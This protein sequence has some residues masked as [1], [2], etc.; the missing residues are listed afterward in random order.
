MSWFCDVF[1]CKWA[2][3]PG[4]FPDYCVRCGQVC[5]EEEESYMT[6]ADAAGGT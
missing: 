6:L 3:A 1:G 4:V 5:L 2:S